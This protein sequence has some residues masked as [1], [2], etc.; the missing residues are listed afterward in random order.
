MGRKINLR[1]V[2]LTEIDKALRA[3]LRSLAAVEPIS[4]SDWAAKHFYLSAES[5]YVEQRWQAYPYQHAIMNAISNDEIE[6]VTFMKSARVGYTKMILA[7]IGYFAEHKRRNQALWQPTD[8]DS[9][10]FCKTELE[11]MIRDVPVMETVFPG[12]LAKSK[13]NTLKQKRFLGSSLHLRGGKAA[14]NYRRLSVDVAILDELDGFDIDVEK[15]GSPVTLARK[16]IEGATFPKLVTGSTPKLK[17]FSLIEARFDQ[18]DKRFYVHVPCPHCGEMIRLRWGGKD[19]A[20]GFKWV[21]DD[22]DTVMHACEQCG[23]LMSQADYLAGWQHS[24]WIAADGTWIDDQSNYRDAAGELIATPK[25]IGFHIW[26]AYSPQTSWAQIVREFLSAKTKASGGDKS[27]LKTFVNTTLGE[28]WEEEV[29]KADLHALMARAESY[30]LRQVQM[31]GLVLVA[32]VDT[33]DNRFEVVVWAIGRGEEMWVVDYMVIEA[34][35]ADERDWDKLGTYLDTRFDHV[36][37]GSLRIEAAALDTGG[38]F[39]H[40]AY[41]FVRHAGASSRIYA[42][43]G[44]PRQGHPVKGRASMQ[45]VNWRGKVIKNGIKLWHVGTDTAKDLLFGRLKVTQ[46]G[47]GYVHFSKDLP[48]E[49]YHQ[50]TA[51]VRMLQKVASGEQYRWVK[52]RQ[53][54]EV[55]DCTVYGIFAAHTLDLHRYTERMWQKLEEVVQPK[56]GDLFGESPAAPALPAPSAR[57]A[58]SGRSAGNGWLDGLEVNL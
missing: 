16:R 41:N 24:R 42:I 7:A 52:V 33:Q 56:N 11:P 20:F 3:G 47:P 19:K 31:G 37:G 13:D 50:L 14:K 1:L 57:P 17:G 32:G 53:R 26:T 15:E 4:L 23:G 36:A 6:E 9:D 49:F 58:A 21:N 8:D 44:E 46:P 10:E 12:F 48:A 39:T 5:S 40:Q 22:P 35:P 27:E 34:N 51:E 18:A 55:L 28:T 45:D 38:H 29:E 43:R 30:P 54:N 25:R 2:D